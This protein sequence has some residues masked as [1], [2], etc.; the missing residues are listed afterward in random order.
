MNR[1]NDDK[2]LKALIRLQ[3]TMTKAGVTNELV[4]KGE[5]KSPLD[6]LVCDHAGIAG[7][8]F[9]PEIKSGEN[10]F[11]F[12]CLMVIDGKA[13][14]KEAKALSDLLSEVNTE[15]VCGMF[16]VFPGIGL[17]YRL[18]VPI[19]ESISD[20]AL[21]ETMDIAAAHAMALSAGFEKRRAANR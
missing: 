14:K 6:M 17:A 10:V 18:T 19:P 11:Y 21:F 16:A 3:E 15:L 1:A 13:D 5:Q 9:F 8:Y 7:Q 20:D 4:K 12:S 2:R